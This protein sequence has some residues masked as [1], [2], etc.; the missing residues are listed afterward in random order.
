MAVKYQD[1]YEVLEVPRGASQEEIRKAYRKLARTYHPDVN[2]SKE[3]EERFK[4]IGEAYEVLGDPQK[5]KRYDALG[6]NWSSGQDFTPP[7]G[8][9]FFGQQGARNGGGAFHFESFGDSPFEGGGF[10]D[11]FE[12]LF[13]GGLGGLGGFRSRQTPDDLGAALRGQNGGKAVGGDHEAE[14]TISLEDAYHGARK[15]ISLETESFEGGRPKRSV[16]RLEV[17]IP[18]GSTEG[19][20][21]RLAGQG[22]KRKGGT[23]A[24]DLYLNVHIAPHPRFRL[25]GADVEV[26]VPVT[27]WEAA[28]GAKIEVP[29]IGG[30]ATLTLPAGIESGKK[31]RLRGKGLSSADGRTG[32]LYAVIRIAVPKS[33]TRRERELFEELARTSSFSPRR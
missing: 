30:S 26:E 21:L 12:M 15:Q 25:D 7:P 23:G 9:D 5:R 27:P 33:L 11:F 2:K 29:I 6:E 28:L 22:A 1:Y 13:G 18:P 31:L 24:G 10:S 17:T 3:A 32:D 16:K 14:I 19:K 4:R 20:R 8:W